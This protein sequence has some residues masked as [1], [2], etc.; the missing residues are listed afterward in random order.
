[1]CIISFYKQNDEIVLT[2]NRDEAIDRVASLEVETREWN[3]KKFSAP[4]DQ[5]K[6]GTWIFYSEEFIACIL[7]GGKVKPM[8]L[9]ST[10]RK[11]RGIVLLELM[12]YDSVK[13]YAENENLKD[14]APFT[15]FVFER[16]ST[17][18]YLLFWDGISLEMNDLSSDSFVFRASSTLYSEI[19][20][21]DIEKKFCTF[22]ITSPE[23]LFEIHQTIKIKDGDVESGKAT[24][25][26]TQIFANSSEISMKYCPFF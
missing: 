23:A 10:Y 20:M 25:S 2:H 9:K 16:K 1:M 8:N 14:I 17:K 6:N 11:S 4:I 24:T 5:K 15:I 21:R 13:E 12:N 26:I 18:I 19:N 3:G 22:N 7:N